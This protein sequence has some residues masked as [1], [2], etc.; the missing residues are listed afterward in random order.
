MLQT[1]VIG[2][3]G[4]DAQVQNRDGQEFV[5]FRVAHN[6]SWTDQAGQQ[7]SNTIWV[8]CIMNGHP[9][10]ADFI[11]AGTQVVCIGRTSLRVY[12]S[13]KDRC[14]KAGIQI[15]VDS[16][17]LLGGAS[18]DVPR[19]LY[20]ANG[21]QHDVKKWYLTDVKDTEL[22]NVRGDHFKVD[23][24]GWV[25]PVKPNNSDS[26]AQTTVVQIY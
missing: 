22:L 21:A 23:A 4:A 5:T 17:Q 9:K 15:K 26:N 7:H 18:D 3:V 1:T 11:K 6:D 12:S 20:D 25:S 24:N 2:N 8:D 19:R 16:V 14:M 13:E 10:V